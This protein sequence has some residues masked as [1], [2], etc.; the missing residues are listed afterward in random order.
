MAPGHVLAVRQKGAEVT[1]SSRLLFSSV[2]LPDERAGIMMVF[3]TY[4]D[5][6]FALIMEGNRAIHVHDYFEKP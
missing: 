3:K 6:S 4:K 1:D 2:E 5:I